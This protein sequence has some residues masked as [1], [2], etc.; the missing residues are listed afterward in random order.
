MQRP[1]PGQGRSYITGSGYGQ[2]TL[3][4]RH[5]DDTVEV[6][7]TKKQLLFMQTTP[8]DHRA[9]QTDP[10]LVLKL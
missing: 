7:G 1:S 10:T 4:S 2:G 8:S 6:V 5:T 3:R 9:S